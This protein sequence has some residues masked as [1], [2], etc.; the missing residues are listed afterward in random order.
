M[1]KGHVVIVEGV[2][3]KRFLKCLVQHLGTTDVEIIEMGGG[4]TAELRA[5]RNLIDRR[6]DAG[7]HISLVVDADNSPEKRRREFERCMI[8]LKLVQEELFLIPD[9]KS[10]GNLEVLLEELA[11]REHKD[12]HSCF[13][14]YENCL[15][16][17]EIYRVPNGKAR[18]F[19]YCEALGAEPKGRMREYGDSRCWNLGAPA[20]EPLKAFLQNF[21]GD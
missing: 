5:I 13:S 17:R 6:R 4:T 11:P 10:K 1:T 20:V 16:A 19:A 3:D 8:E 21:I 12:I 18:I 14:Q 7:M 15:K 9:N 2:D